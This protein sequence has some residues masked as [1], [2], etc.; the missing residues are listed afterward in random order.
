MS[1][2]PD[3][4]NPKASEI[5]LMAHSLAQTPGSSPDSVTGMA[6]YGQP[7][8][9]LPVFTIARDERRLRG[10]DRS[11]TIVDEKMTPEQ[12][13]KQVKIDAL[14]TRFQEELRLSDRGV[15]TRKQGPALGR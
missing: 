7:V 5:G 12:K 9:D 8:E 14:N 3:E 4:R 13:A 1:K 15:T 11:G 6:G 10:R 2:K